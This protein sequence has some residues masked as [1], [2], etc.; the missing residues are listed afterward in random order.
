MA[1]RN[2]RCSPVL[3]PPISSSDLAMS[4]VRLRNP[5]GG[6]SEVFQA[7][8]DGLGGGRGGRPINPTGPVLGFVSPGAK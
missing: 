6:T 1:H 8:V 2:R 4:L 7:A 5:R 3:N